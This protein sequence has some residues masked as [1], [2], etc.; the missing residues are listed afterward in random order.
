[1]VHHGPDRSRGH[2][3]A[4][5]PSACRR[6]T[7]C[8][9]PTRWSPATSTQLTAVRVGPAGARRGAAGQEPGHGA[10]PGGAPARAPRRRIA[11]T[12]TPVENRL[13]ELWSI[14]HLLNPGPAGH[15]RA[16]FRER[17]AV[18]IE[19]D[20]DDEATELLRRV[21]GAVRA[22]PAQDR[23]IDHRR[24]AR[25]DRADR[26]LP[27]HPGA[28]HALPGG[29]R[30]PAPGGRRAPRASTGA[31]LVLAGPR[32]SSSRSATT[33]PSSC[34]DGSRA[35][36][37]ARASSTRVEELL[38]EIVDA[39][40]KV[41]CFTQFAEWGELLG[42]LPRAPLGSEPLWLHGGVP[43]TA[44]DEMVAALRS[45]PDG[46]PIFLLSLKAGGTGLNLTAASH[47][48]HLDRWWNPA[49]E[50]QAT[51]RAYRIGQRRDGAGAQA[52]LAGTV[53]ERIDEHDRRQAGAGRS[54]WSAP[55]RSGSPSS[56]PTSCARCVA[57]R[58]RRVRRGATDAAPTDWDDPWNRWS[59]VVGPI[60]A[61]GGIATSQAARA[62]WPPR[63]GRGGSSR[64]SSRYG[65]GGRMQRGRRYARA[66][67]VLTLDVTPGRDRRPG[68]GLAPHAVR[69]VDP[70]AP[71]PSIEQWAAVE[72]AMRP[73]SGSWRGCSPARCR[74]SSRTCS[75]T[76]ASTCSRTV[77]AARRPAAAVPTGRTRASTS[78]R[79]STCSPTSSTRPVAAADLAGPHAETSSSPT[80]MPW[81]P[82]GEPM[83]CPCGGRSCREAPTST[84]CAGDPR[85][86]HRRSRPMLRSPASAT[87]MPPSATPRS[88]SLLAGA[89][90]TLIAPEET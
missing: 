26:A 15:A 74:R 33:R 82:P 78:P 60:P 6:T 42:A 35:R 14:M 25:Q 48:I 5:S 56:P 18:P 77:V 90:P 75:P 87:S 65:L 45:D 34:G 64:C 51:D 79:C 11:L 68:A 76:P 13:A 63:G 83:A 2:D 86:R 9:P 40:D 44:R 81:H 54:G 32:C 39:G 80:S 4:A 43:R 59:G 36:P 27:A 1:M 30:R 46:P 8:S 58:V 69:G 37:A 28:G 3:D 88:A 47:V 50:D 53:E 21:T 85:R 22:A 62:P 84:G 61:E 24:P 38:E 41:L 49:V 52:R 12:G 31:A 17:F 67:Q 20:G 55:A 71:V 57:L 7:W 66:G 29:G 70:L 73:G 16:A 89:Y 72:E 19:R 23:P 10:G